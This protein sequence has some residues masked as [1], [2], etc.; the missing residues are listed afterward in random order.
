[1][2]GKGEIGFFVKVLDF[3]IFISLFEILI[4]KGNF[5]GILVKLSVL[6]IL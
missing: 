5:G 3:R 6:E 4:C 2:M 1:M